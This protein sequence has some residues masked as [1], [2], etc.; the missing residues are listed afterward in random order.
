MLNL[1]P[2]GSILLLGS[3]TKVCIAFTFH[4][5]EASMS[6]DLTIP[7]HVPAMTLPGVVLFPRAIMPIYIFEPR[8][9]TMLKNVLDTNRLLIIVGQNQQKADE[10]DLFE[11]CYDIASVSII[12]ASHQAEDGS[13]NLIVQGLKRVRVKQIVQEEPFRIVE[14]EV[15]ESTV[16]SDEADLD[17]QK[18][19][20]GRLFDVHLKLGGSIPGEV[21][22][23]L[24][25]LQDPEIFLDIA[26]YTLCAET[27]KKQRILE[28]IN[29]HH[30][31]R[32]FIDYFR[33]KNQELA[34]EKKLRGGLDDE[35]INLN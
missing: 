24:K 8:Y 30:R 7:S 29:P 28:M 20:L 16:G 25:D 35:Q 14:I 10:T 2:N 17:A 15:I 32:Y 1:R 22:K 9:R 19:A 27:R 3:E 4:Y 21:M 5:G 11:P 33:K 34:L 23:V 31:Y 6:S 18:A 13:S 26:A 12:R